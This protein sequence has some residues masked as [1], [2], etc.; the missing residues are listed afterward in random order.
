MSEI[1]MESVEKQIFSQICSGNVIRKNLINTITERDICSVSTLDRILKKFHRCGLVKKEGSGQYPLTEDG[2]KEK[3]RT[4][5][6]PTVAFKNSGLAK[7]IAKLPTEA[8]QGLIY[9][10]LATIVAKKY[11]AEKLGEGG[12]WGNFIISGRPKD[13]KTLLAE[14]ICRT[15]DLP[16]TTHIQRAIGKSEAQVLGEATFIDPKDGLRKLR[17]PPYFLYPFICW[18]DLDK[19]S[20][21]GAW[22]SLMVYLDGRYKFEERYT[23]ITKQV[24]TLATMNPKKKGG[25]DMPDYYVR[26]AFTVNS[27]NLPCDQKENEKIG[28]DITNNPIP[29]LR[30]DNLVAVKEEITL[31]EA[32]FIRDLLYDRWITEEAKGVVDANLLHAVIL[33]MLILQESLDV[34]YYSYW[35]VLHYLCFL[36]TLGYTKGDWE[37]ELTQEWGDYASGSSGDEKFKK[38]WEEQAK[39]TKEEKAKIDEGKKGKID[40]GKEDKAVKRGEEKARG[41]GYATKM[42]RLMEIRDSFAEIEKKKRVSEILICLDK[43]IKDLKIKKGQSASEDRITELTITLTEWEEQHKPIRE[44]WEE[45][46]KKKQRNKEIDEKNLRGITNWK[47]SLKKWRGKDSKGVLWTERVKPVIA[48]IGNVLNNDTQKKYLNNTYL[49]EIESDTLALIA[50][51]RIQEEEAGTKKA[52]L[53]EM[54]QVLSDVIDDLTREESAEVI[55][56]AVESVGVGEPFK[57]TRTVPYYEY[58]LI[59]LDRWLKGKGKNKPEPRSRTI[60]EQIDY[61]IRG[62]KRPYDEFD[63]T[64]RNIDDL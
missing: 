13:I 2:R 24:T 27:A 35:A 63:P 1:V 8:H 48:K 47:A 10:I 7:V 4:K 55:E 32:D 62:G 43:D 22:N 44:A 19:A 14:M 39:K 37:E 3:K 15:L 57:T 20:T 54:P 38:E 17:L 33:G 18:N 59:K 34:R 23:P 28:M 29:K 6:K 31:D 42:S 12:V 56:E 26:R 49:R 58:L 51:V 30:I 36:K 9:F 53:V 25:F 41:A 16:F 52:G 21:R 45:A 50:E 40:K 64:Q 11:L 5:T 61:E 46:Q 60:E